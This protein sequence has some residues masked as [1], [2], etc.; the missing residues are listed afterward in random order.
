[1][2]NWIERVRRWEGPQSWFEIKKA[3]PTDRKERKK[4][5]FCFTKLAKVSDQLLAL[6]VDKSFFVFK[7]GTKK[8]R[9]AENL[10]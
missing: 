7:F 2:K 10:K 1:M 6:T 9:A 4:E 5:S 3:P 8:L